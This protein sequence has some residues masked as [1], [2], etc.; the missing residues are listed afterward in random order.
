MSKVKKMLKEH[1]P[2]G[3]GE[4]S[5]DDY[6]DMY[7]LALELEKAFETSQKDMRLIKN[8]LPITRKDK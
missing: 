7:S 4:F 6:L 3:I 2:H 8:Q 5:N 1:D